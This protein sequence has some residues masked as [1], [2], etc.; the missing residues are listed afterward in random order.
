ML[1]NDGKPQGKDNDMADTGM[2]EVTG[3]EV[4]A[5]KEDVERLRDDLGSLLSDMG[6]FSREKLA[7]TRDRL[8][9]AIGAVEGRAYGKMQGTA[10]VM[11]DRSQQAVKASRGAVEQKPLTYVMAAFAAG[12]VLASLFEWKKNP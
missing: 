11:R 8:G 3:A 1:G 12:L 2:N 7:D 10:R 5:I 6:S 4:D 9:A